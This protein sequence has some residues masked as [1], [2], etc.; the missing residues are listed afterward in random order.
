[1]WVKRTPEEIVI[2]K[3]KH[4]SVRIR[5][6]VFMGIFVTVLCAFVRGNRLHAPGFVPLDQVLSRP[7]MP[8]VLGVIVGIIN[9]WFALRDDCQLVCPKCGT[10]KFR[11]NILQCS[12]GGHFEK[13]EE[14][15]WHDHKK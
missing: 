12:C 6:A 8:V 15:K 7:V 10:I 13:I 9:F 11:D 2:T 14:M 1:M 3:R 5:T 4:L